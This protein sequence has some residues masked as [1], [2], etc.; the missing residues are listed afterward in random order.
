MRLIDADK[1]DYWV[2]ANDDGTYTTPVTSVSRVN[3]MPS[4]NAIPKRWIKV[5]GRRNNQKEVI[6]KLFDDWSEYKQK[7]IGT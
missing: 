6:Q 4:I 2:T 5:W 1:I 7:N 3:K